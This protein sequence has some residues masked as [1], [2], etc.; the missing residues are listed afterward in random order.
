MA[1][2]MKGSA[3]KLGNIQGTSGHTS[4]SALKHKKD[5]GHRHGPGY[6]P[7]SHMDEFKEYR[8][9]LM[10]QGIEMKGTNERDSQGD[11]TGKYIPSEGENLLLA[12]RDKIKTEINDPTMPTTAQIKEQGIMGDFSKESTTGGK[13]GKILETT[14][15][16]TDVDPLQMK[17]PTKKLD[18]GRLGKGIATGGLS[19]I[20]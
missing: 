11:Y 20:F 1:F 9:S 13:G 10:D 17:S 4:A 6:I 15:E 2:K 8:K 19:E 7:R 5:T 3:F 12:W 16:V 18:W 14:G